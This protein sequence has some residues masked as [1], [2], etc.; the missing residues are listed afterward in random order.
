M[1]E[2][3]EHV[4]EQYRVTTTSSIKE[5]GA[6][7]TVCQHHGHRTGQYRDN[8]NQQEGG[9]QPGPHEQRHLH[10]GH[11][12]GTHVEDSYYHVDR[13]HDGGDTHHVNGQNEQVGRCRTVLG[14]Q[15]RVE[16]PAEV[17]RAGVTGTK[18]AHQHG[19]DQDAKGERQDPE[20][21]VVH[22]RQRHIRRTDHQRDHPVGQA[23]RGGHYR[24]KHH[25]QTVHG[26]HLVEEFRIHE[27]HA[28]LEK[29]GTNNHGHET[30]NQEHGKAEPQ[31]QGTD[32]FVVGAEQPAFQAGRGVVMIVV[33]I[34]GCSCSRHC[35]PLPYSWSLTSA[36]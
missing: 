3:P 32:V 18:G 23:N 33:I 35:Y 36:G 7:V 8:G 27:L 11:A 2:E 17:R 10:Q 21:P 34:M 16:S 13:T 14:R 30:A 4:L 28:R 12:R 29:L 19:E 20:G 22:P 26:G 15:R 6:E 31:V 5:A 24:T 9:N 25:D 1:P